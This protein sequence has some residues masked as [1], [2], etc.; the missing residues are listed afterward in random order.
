M[1]KVSEVF[2]HALRFNESEGLA[3]FIGR[4]ERIVYHL[5]WVA[6]DEVLRGNHRRAVPTEGFEQGVD[7]RLAS[8]S[9]VRPNCGVVAF[10]TFSERLDDADK[11]VGV[12][13]IIVL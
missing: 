5:F 9:L 10:D 3:S 2:L 1:A 6:S 13:V 8:T 4:M 7:E 11:G 12:Y